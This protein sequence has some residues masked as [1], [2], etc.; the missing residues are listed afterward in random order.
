MT[1]N[2]LLEGTSLA[3][4]QVTRLNAAYERALRALYLVDRN[5]PLTEIIAKKIIEISQTGISD[6][7]QISQRAVEDLKLS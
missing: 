2:R 1:I 5:D 3:Q 4:E 7:A 6:P